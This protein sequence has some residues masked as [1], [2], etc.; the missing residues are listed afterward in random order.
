MGMAPWLRPW[1]GLRGSSCSPGFFPA[2]TQ[3]EEEAE[4]EWSCSHWR[5]PPCPG[6]LP[7]EHCI[8]PQLLCPLQF[9]QASQQ[10]RWERNTGLNLT[11][12][13]LILGPAAVSHR[14]QLSRLDGWREHTTHGLETP[15]CHQISSPCWTSTR[16]AHG[17]AAGSARIPP[18]CSECHHTKWGQPSA[19]LRFCGDLVA[20]SS[21]VTKEQLEMWQGRVRGVLGKG[22]PPKGEGRH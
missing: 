17:S 4:C 7:S 5:F 12:Q 6:P 15:S 14:S 22:S 9:P 11:P 19:F 8:I 18:V 13:Q 21:L 16:G 20:W 3:R 1:Q 2:Q 10:P